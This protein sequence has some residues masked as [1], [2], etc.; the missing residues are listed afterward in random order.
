M[1]LVYSICRTI[2]DATESNVHLLQIRFFFF[3][4][5]IKFSKYTNNMQITNESA[6]KS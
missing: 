1:L 5:K 6:F 4:N 3:K 2:I